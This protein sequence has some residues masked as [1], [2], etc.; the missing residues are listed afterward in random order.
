MALLAEQLVDEWL[1]RNGFPL[2]AELVKIF[3]SVLGN[4]GATLE[5]NVLSL[6]GDSLQAIKVAL[7]LE[8][9]F[10]IAIP[11]DVF[12]SIQTIRELARWLT[13]R[14]ASPTPDFG[15]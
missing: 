3:E 2:I 7:E 5:D 1:N 9:H 4:V 11:A 6:G 15:R 14:K 10:G 13:V 12:E 8:K